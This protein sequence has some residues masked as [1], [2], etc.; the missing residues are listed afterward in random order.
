[1]AMIPYIVGSLSNITQ[2][3]RLRLASFLAT[4][5]AIGPEA[6]GA[7]KALTARTRFIPADLFGN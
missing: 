4:P 5:P 2:P 3:L 1:M 6:H 7:Y